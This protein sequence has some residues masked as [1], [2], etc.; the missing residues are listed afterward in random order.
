M[1]ERN[2]TI[3]EFIFMWIAV[4]YLFFGIYLLAIFNFNNHFYIDFLFMV[5]IIFLTL[6]GIFRFK[7][8]QFIKEMQEEIK[9]LKEGL[10]SSS[11]S[12]S[13]SIFYPIPN[14]I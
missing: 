11:I 2:Y 3:L 7:R 10:N 9:R 4:L 6:S 8:D 5:F 12:F 13:A 1:N 14:N